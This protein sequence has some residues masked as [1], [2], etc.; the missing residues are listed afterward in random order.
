MRGMLESGSVGAAADS[1]DVAADADGRSER[2]PQAATASAP[3]RIMRRVDF[4]IEFYPAV[5][6][7]DFAQDL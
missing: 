2:R 3:L 7:T 5:S 1:R 6:L 4:M